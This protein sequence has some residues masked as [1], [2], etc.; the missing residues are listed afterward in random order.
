MGRL[1][2]GLL[3]YA[4][5]HPEYNIPIKDSISFC[6]L[7]TAPTQ[8]T[9]L[10]LNSFA[11]LNESLQGII[12]DFINGISN[13]NEVISELSEDID[14][15][16]HLLTEES[17]RLNSIFNIAQEQSG[18]ML[19]QKEEIELILN[20]YDRWKRVLSED[21]LEEIARVS[22]T[23][24]ESYNM[25]L[26]KVMS[27]LNKNYSS[28]ALISFYFLVL[29]LL[30]NLLKQGISFV[31]N[32]APRLVNYYSRASNYAVVDSFTYMLS[33]LEKENDALQQTFITK[34]IIWPD[35]RCLTIEGD[36]KSGYIFK[37]YTLAPGDPQKEVGSSSQAEYSFLNYNDI[38]LKYEDAKVKF[39]YNSE[40][41]SYIMLAINNCNNYAKVIMSYIKQ[42]EV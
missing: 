24:L 15:L 7:G 33:C 36:I 19:K 9:I 29:A 20:S 39:A 13:A 37:I 5:T 1:S 41:L 22:D 40:Q 38:I 16:F 25:I 42:I 8:K 11:I 32:K 18:G 17:I 27:I 14:V 6:C 21:N 4:G 26:N 28:Y 10:E 34:T 31:S 2:I 12:D 30:S 23:V 3:E 35:K